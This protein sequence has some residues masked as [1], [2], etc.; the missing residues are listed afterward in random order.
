M[1]VV[2]IHT[3]TQ[4]HTQTHTHTH[5]H[6]HISEIFIY[7]P[8]WL[9]GKESACSARDTAVASSIPG[10]GRSTGR[11]NGN[12]LQYSCLDNSIDRGSWWA[13]IHR[14][15][16]SW[17]QLSTHVAHICK[18]MKIYIIWKWSMSDDGGWEVPRSTVRR[19]ETQESFWCSRSPNL[20]VWELGELID[21]LKTKKR[22]CFS[23][24]LKAEK[25]QYSISSHQAGG[26]SNYS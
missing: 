4:T 18:Y 6:T 14:I 7:L 15:A 23:L 1:K 3:D 21:R 2:Y 12:P 19:L 13:L 8:R 10:P 5:T 26:V 17:T 25:D 20:K 11:G 22:Q 24:N 9:S 16:K